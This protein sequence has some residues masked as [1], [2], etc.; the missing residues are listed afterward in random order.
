MSVSSKILVIF[1]VLTGLIA[2]IAVKDHK[3]KKLS[4]AV[5]RQEVNL[6]AYDSENSSLESENRAFKYTIQEYKYR[7][8]S[9]L[10]KLRQVQEE[11]GIKDSKLKQVQYLL[12]QSARTDT[13]FMADTIFSDSFIEADTVIG[14]KWFSVRLGLYYPNL[15]SVSPSFVSEL[16]IF[17]S[18]RKETINKRKKFFLWRL[19][20]KKHTVLITDIYDSN[21]YSSVKKSKFIEIVD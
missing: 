9:V 10:F 17:T 2:V 16:S 11:L 20:Q 19:F 4:D 13:V 18:A 6:K 14:D 7:H 21:P 5:S 8:D 3:I 1:L 15:I 12:T